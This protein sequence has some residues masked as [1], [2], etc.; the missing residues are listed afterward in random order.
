MVSGQRWGKY[1]PTVSPSVTDTIHFHQAYTFAR[2]F[3]LDDTWQKLLFCSYF[4]LTNETPLWQHTKVVKLFF[5]H[6]TDGLYIRLCVCMLHQM[7]RLH[8][9]DLQ[10]LVLNS[11]TFQKYLVVCSILCTICDIKLEI[12]IVKYNLLKNAMS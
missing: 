6:L 5:I 1:A 8:T 3:L 9:V 10:S 2:L 12:Y 7:T 11:E 4:T